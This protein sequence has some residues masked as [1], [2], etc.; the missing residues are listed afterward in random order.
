MKI[1][2]LSDTHLG[3]DLPFKPR[4]NRRRRGPDFFRMFR[5]ALQSALRGEV[6]AV[7]HGG[8]ILFR[9]KVPPELVQM[10]FEPLHEVADKGVPVYLV[11][12][13][14][15]R[16][17]IPYPMLATHPN[18]H[19]FVRPKTFYLEI[20]GKTLA[21]AGFPYHRDNVRENFPQVLEMTGWRKKPFD[22]A[23]LCIHHCIEG[24]A[25]QQ[26]E[27]MY[28]FRNNEDVIRI[29][30]FPPQ[31]SAVLCG[32]IHRFQVLNRDLN[33]NPGPVPVFYPGSTER[34]SFQEKD[35]AKGYLLLEI[36]GLE[37]DQRVD[38]RVDQRS[39]HTASVPGVSFT[40]CQLP[41]RPMVQLDVNAS[42]MSGS[43]LSA[44]IK[45]ALAA[46]AEDS[47]VQIRIR[48]RLSEDCLKAVN[49]ASLREITPQL[50]NLTTSLPDMKIVDAR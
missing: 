40:F 47:V 11:P 37:A 21:L 2:F 10:A 24:C 27:R 32:H 38:Q 43:Q 28:V 23:L 17:K 3:F 16:S 6:D 30:Q 20:R 39:D 14:H 13:N 25:I 1:L 44:W 34:T 41:A 15:E 12:G 49:A 4:I 7:I 31:F 33:G 48:G 42:A 29:N 36:T 50:M 26:G 46:L 5:L 9:S 8:D 35:E 19:I 45:E 18:I 22:A